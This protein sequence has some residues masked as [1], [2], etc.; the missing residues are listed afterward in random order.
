M[1]LNFEVLCFSQMVWYVSLYLSL[2]AFSIQKQQ[3]QQHQVRDFGKQG[4]QL[5]A[6]KRGETLTSLNITGVFQVGEKVFDTLGKNCKK[7]DTLVASRWPLLNSTCI[8][9][10]TCSNLTRIDLS[11][12]IDIDDDCLHA[13]SKSCKRLR[14]VNLTQCET[15]S[16][17]GVVWLVRACL[18]LSNLNLEGCTLVSDL[19]LLAMSETKFHPGLRRLNFT[20]LDRITETGV[21]WLAQ[22]CS[23]LLS[24]NLKGCT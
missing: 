14:V 13:L 22:T 23:T 5:L 11:H 7:L 10:L 15:I 4:L 2:F 16:D 21:T 19:A 12:N 8:R 24:M 18:E 17:R 3:Q 9:N 20:G 1:C 6:E